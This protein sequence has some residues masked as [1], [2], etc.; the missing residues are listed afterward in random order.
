[1]TATPD[2]FSSFCFLE[3]KDLREMME[4][5]VSIDMLRQNLNVGLVSGFDEAGIIAG[6]HIPPLV[7]NV[8]E[9][10]QVY[11]EAINRTARLHLTRDDNVLWRKWD[12][13]TEAM[14]CLSDLI[15]K[16]AEVAVFLQM[17]DDK[18]PGVEAK[19]AAQRVASMK[20][21]TRDALDELY[22]RMREFSQIP[23]LSIYN[24]HTVK[25]EEASAAVNKLAV[26]HAEFWKRAADAGEDGE[27]TLKYFADQDKL[28]NKEFGR[29]QTAL[30]INCENLPKLMEMAREYE[31]SM[32]LR[33]EQR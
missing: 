23:L 26:E 7:R 13:C 24:M 9:S 28:N 16:Q 20:E 32:M 10:G 2:Q 25:L 31:H 8:H 27:R 15:S 12:A 4:L 30:Q 22:D 18:K 29:I 5:C 14:D 1:M 17:A 19:F 33:R 6:R 3:P 21:G 11:D